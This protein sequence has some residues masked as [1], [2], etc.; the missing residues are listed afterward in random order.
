[1]TGLPLLRRYVDCILWGSETRLG[2]VWAA[3]TAMQY[4]WVSPL[5]TLLPVD[6]ALGEVDRFWWAGVGLSWGELAEGT[7]RPTP[8]KTFC[9]RCRSHK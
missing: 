4:S 3:K 2:V 5:R 8:N 7:V 9:A 6:Q 1:M